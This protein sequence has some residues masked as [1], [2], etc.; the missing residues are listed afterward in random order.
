MRQLTR[1]RAT[2]DLPVTAQDRFRR[3]ATNILTIGTVTKA[4]RDIESLEVTTLAPKIEGR[5][6]PIMK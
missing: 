5:I 3:V 2:N 4:F 6:T 1:E